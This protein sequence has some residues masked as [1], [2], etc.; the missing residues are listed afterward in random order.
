VFSRCRVA[1]PLTGKATVMAESSW[2]ICRTS[3]LFC[4]FALCIS[5]PLQSVSLFGRHAVGEG[6]LVR[7]CDLSMTTFVF[8]IYI[9]QSISHFAPFHFAFRTNNS[10]NRNKA[11]RGVSDTTKKKKDSSNNNDINSSN[12]E[13]GIKDTSAT[14]SA[15]MA[16]NSSN[17]NKAKRRVS[18]TVSRRKRKRTAATTTTS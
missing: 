9:N 11:K 2:S 15:R 10:S 13:I 5:S 1:K 12:A 6:I 3:V 8:C 16:N 4:F 14:L 17:R 7:F 18:D